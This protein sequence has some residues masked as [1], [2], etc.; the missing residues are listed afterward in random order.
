MKGV[1]MANVRPFKGVRPQKHLVERIASPPYDVLNSKEAREMVKGNEYSFLHITKPEVDL[2][3]DIH[4]YDDAIYA[5]AAANLKA[6]MEKEWMIQD[7]TPCYYIYK[8][9][10]GEHVQTGLVAAASVD[11]YENNIIK[12]HEFTRQDKEDDRTRHVYALNANTGPVFLTYQARE[13]LDSFIAAYMEHNAPVYH[14]TSHDSIDVIHTF[15]AVDDQDAI[16]KIQ[17]EF[18]QIPVLYVA[19]GHHRSAAAT[20]VRKMKKDENSGHTGE[21]EY[22]FFL[23]VIFPHD[24]MYIMDYNRVLKDLNGL[25]PES[26]MSAVDQFFTVKKKE[27]TGE[28]AKPSACHEFS[29]FF[30]G[31][32]YSLQA[33]KGT[34]DA[35]DP[36]AS[37]DVAIL[38]NNLLSPV[39]GIG[40][41]RKDD[42][43]DFVGGI[44]GMKELEKCVKSGDYV[45]AFALYPTSINQLMD[46]ADAGKVMPPKSTW[47]E[48]KLRSGLCVHL[49]D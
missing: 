29:M 16:K 6:F 40:D 37:L 21:E 7:S 32:W 14:F 18:D 30:K 19:D 8:Q 49:L 17:N 28:A 4:L 13:S 41:P 1:L 45:L 15:W 35:D 44:R 22:N 36:I 20:R 2:R 23:S 48:P 24:Q 9:Q 3:E 27:E 42:R 12:K 10:M 43:I 31:E 39:L 38:Q 11:D 33:K 25:T 34:F 5:K 47:F 46:V 26:F